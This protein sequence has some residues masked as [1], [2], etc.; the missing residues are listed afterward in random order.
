M[1]WSYTVK[2]KHLYTKEEDYASIQKSMSA[3]AGVLE[4]HYAFIP[5]I[6][7]IKKFYLIPEGD[8]FF[9]PV[10]YANKLL[11]RMYD[12]ADEHRIWID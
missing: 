10:D 1:A 3:I 9:S 5:F 2:I 4:K 6:P 8:D 12:F 11:E 7:T